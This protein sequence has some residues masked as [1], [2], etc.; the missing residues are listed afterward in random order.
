MSIGRET[1]GRSRRLDLVL[2]LSGAMLLMSGCATHK[3]PPAPVT[4]AHSEFVYPTVPAALKGRPGADL[5]DIGWRYLQSNNNSAADRTFAQAL[6]QNAA[7]YPARAGQG[8]VALAKRDFPHALSSFDSALAMSPSYAPALVGRGQALIALGRE[9]E[10][11][12]ALEAAIAA[13]SSLTD[14]QRR[15]DVLRFRSIQELIESARDATRNGRVADARAAYERAIAASPESAFLY[16]ELGL[17]DRKSGQVDQA[18]GRFRRA[19]DLDPMDTVSLIQIGELLEERKDYAGAEAAYRKAAQIDPTP[20]LSTRIA[21]AAKNAREA[22]LPPEFQAALTSTQLSRGELAALIGVRL[23]G[24]LRDAPAR[25]VVVT[26]TRGHWAAEWMMMVAQAGVMDPYDN[27][28]FQ[29]RA[30]VRRGDL[31]TAMSRLLG[32]I[33]M[34]DPDLR[35]RIAQRPAIADLTPRHTQYAAAAA[36]VATGVMPL[37][38][39]DR[40]QVAQAVT[41]PEATDAIERVRALSTRTQTNSAF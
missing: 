12:P 34:R 1:R 25:Q 15:I 28:T 35:T 29:P 18:L 31:A 10:A 3:V 4:V 37:L 23:E 9:R 7:L 17:L 14:V 11:L 32:L 22:K 2:S 19:A 5:V 24:L 6:R 41:G 40:F 33:A 26:D 13:D 36:V 21:T 39:G 27:H 20:E 8:Y 16:R 30:R 38:A